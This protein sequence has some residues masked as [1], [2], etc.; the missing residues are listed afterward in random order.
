MAA[1]L[2]IGRQGLG[3]TSPNPSVGAVVVA[4]GTDGPVIVGLARTA[5]GGRPHA[6]PIALDAAGAR[7]AGATMYVTLEPCSHHG[8]T[9]PCADAAIRAG[10]R[11]AVVAIED[12]NPLVAGVGVARLLEAGIEVDV[13]L[14]A[15]EARRDLAGHISRMTRGRPHMCLKLA[16]SADGAIGRRGEG[17]IAISGPASRARA[18]LLRAECDAIAVGVGTILADDPALTCRLPGMTACSP[19]RVVFDSAA[20]TPP[21]AR[22]FADIAT[23]PVLVVVGEG[24]DS[25]RT[26]ALAA[27]GADILVVPRDGAHVDLSAALVAL[28]QRGITRVLVEGGAGLADAMVAADLIDEVQWIDAPTRIG[29]GGTLPIAGRGLAALAERFEIIQVE[30]IGDDR[31]THLWRRECSQAS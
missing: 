27:A 10:I 16:V 17:Q 22:L 18:H 25:A 15:A 31:W 8:K 29:P 9:P 24:A 21:T 6:E 28:A 4:P 3:R 5:D 13:G 1:A 20:R 12:P 11:R 26:A 19:L 14:G 2:A 30:T 7:A 23:V